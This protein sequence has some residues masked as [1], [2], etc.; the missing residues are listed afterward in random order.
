MLILNQCNERKIPQR[1]NFLDALL[2]QAT[3][4]LTRHP[5]L[6]AVKQQELL[7]DQGPCSPVSK[8]FEWTWEPRSS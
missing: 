6:V 4:E 7:A 8:W 1:R 5:A 2:I 3:V